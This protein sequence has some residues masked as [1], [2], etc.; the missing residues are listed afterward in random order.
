MVCVFSGN[1]GHVG[2]GGFAVGYA[3]GDM[4][5]V[6]VDFIHRFEGF[7][8]GCCEFQDARLRIDWCFSLESNEFVEVKE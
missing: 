5:F 1:G 8:W 2:I 4:I 7:A 3:V 6:E